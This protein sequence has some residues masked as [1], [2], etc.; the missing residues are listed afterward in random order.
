MKKA[1][2]LILALVMCLSLIPMTAKA[3]G[4]QWIDLAKDNF[5]PKERIN[6]TIKGVTQ[7]MVDK[8]SV[9]IYTKG[10][11]MFTYDVFGNGEKYVRA[12]G[13]TSVRNVGENVLQFEAPLEPGEYVVVLHSVYANDGKMPDIVVSTLTFTV[14]KVAKEGNISLDKTAYKSMDPIIVTYSGITQNMVNSNAMVAIYAKGG[15][16]GQSIGGTATVTLGSGTL[17]MY[18]PNQNG[19]FE[20][21]LYTIRGE[22]NADTF[23][24]SVPFTISGASGADWA[25]LEEANALG[26][27]PDCLKGTDFTKP[28]TRAEFAAVA[29]KLHGNL[30]GEKAPPAPSNTFADTG[31]TEILKAY[32]IGIT[33]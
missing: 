33:N 30:P 22:Y 28:I 21:R 16:H 32:N 7:Q 18:A 14:G 6:V 13:V 26:L 25:R 3:Y 1:L 11:G 4:N 24:M 10:E 8:A 5:D 19:E 20:M 17:T 27:I 15:A 31:E 12:S 9:A 29:V 2:T 23:V